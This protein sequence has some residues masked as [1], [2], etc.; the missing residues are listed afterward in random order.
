MYNVKRLAYELVTPPPEAFTEGPASAAP[1]ASSAPTGT[2]D[3]EIEDI[4]RRVL[5]ELKAA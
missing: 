4:V 2:S 3:T 5:K 1:A